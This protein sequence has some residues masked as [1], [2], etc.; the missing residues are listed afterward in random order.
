MTG[1]PEP[2]AHPL[3]GWFLIITESGASWL[4]KELEY[5]GEPRDVRLGPV[6]RYYTQMVM[7]NG[8]I[9]WLRNLT[10]VEISCAA[11]SLQI[12]EMVVRVAAVQ[13]CSKLDATATR[14]LLAMIDDADRTR[15]QQRAASMGL[16]VAGRGK[17]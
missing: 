2:L 15:I 17:R 13:D 6:Y 7:Q 3:A 8:S 4:G 16:E 11:P 14:E 9:G 5:K 1:E 10:P 12:E